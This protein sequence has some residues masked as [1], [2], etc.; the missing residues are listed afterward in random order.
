MGYNLDEHYGKEVQ[1]FVSSYSVHSYNNLK[2]GFKTILHLAIDEDDYDTTPYIEALLQV[3]KIHFEN[4]S[5]FRCRLVPAQNTATVNCSHRLFM[6]LQRR[7][8]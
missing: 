1:I 8:N 4:I 3:H 6:L 7:S 5:N 2:V